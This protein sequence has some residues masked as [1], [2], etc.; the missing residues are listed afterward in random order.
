MASASAAAPHY[1]ERVDPV[2]HIRTG[3][4]ILREAWCPPCLDYSQDLLRWHCQSPGDLSRFGVVAYE[5]DFPTA[6]VAVN[7]YNTN[8]GPTYFSSFFSAIPGAS[9][10]LSIS[11]IQKLGQT[12]RESGSPCL[13]FAQPNEAGEKTLGWLKRSRLKETRLA[14]ALVYMAAPRTV[15]GTEA[16]ATSP[17]QWLGV[18]EQFPVPES[19][20]VPTWDDAMLLH[21][22]AHPWQRQFLVAT[23]GGEYVGCAIVEQTRIQ[24]RKNQVEILPSLHYVRAEDADAVKALVSAAAKESK[25]VCLPNCTVAPEIMRSATARATSTYHTYLYSSPELPPITA[26]WTEII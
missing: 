7:S 21:A 25:T 15:I 18:Y 12:L 4:M 23:R 5:R 8:L 26:A 1:I 9:P 10:S 22:D 6:F 11:V 14:N 3:S 19:A 17:G 13:I 24:Q 2:E 16:N 20:I